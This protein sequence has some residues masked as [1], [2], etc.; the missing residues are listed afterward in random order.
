[1]AEQKPN[2]F[3]AKENAEAA[4]EKARQEQADAEY[5]S[6]LVPMKRDRRPGEPSHMPTEASVHPDHVADYQQGG[7]NKA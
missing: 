3:A 6:K 2:P 7:W 4:A 1:M 5:T